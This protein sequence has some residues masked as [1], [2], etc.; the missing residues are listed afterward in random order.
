MNLRFLQQ[1]NLAYSIQTDLSAVNG[2]GSSDQ[3]IYLADYAGYRM[4]L[5]AFFISKV[6][7]ICTGLK[8][9]DLCTRFVLPGCF[10]II[11]NFSMNYT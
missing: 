2:D 7:R 5:A 10:A 3:K 8:V 6:F 1:V 11:V 4:I 9:G